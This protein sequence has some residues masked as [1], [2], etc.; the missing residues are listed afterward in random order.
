M[1]ANRL[2]TG[3]K[4][5]GI[6]GALLL[7]IMFIFDWFTIDVGGGVFDVSTGGNAWQSF[8]FIDLARPDDDRT[9]LARFLL[10]VRDGGFDAVSQLIERRWE[11]SFAGAGVVLFLLLGVAVGL[12]V[13]YTF[14]RM[15]RGPRRVHLTAAGRAAAVGLAILAIVGLVS[16]DS[17]AAVPA[18][19]LAVAVPVFLLRADTWIGEST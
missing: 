17:G 14:L 18:V 3:E 13:E 9:H 10:R 7:L 1:D 2:N 15:G 12:L 16:N 19:M 6:S 5:A 4:I 8:G 11:A